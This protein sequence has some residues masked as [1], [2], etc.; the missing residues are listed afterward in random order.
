MGDFLIM[1]DL[2]LDSWYKIR[3]KALAEGQT[4]IGQR[5]NKD[6]PKAKQRSAKDQKGLSQRSN[7][8][9]PKAK[10][11]LAEGQSPPQELEVSPRSGL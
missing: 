9:W 11:A 4:R 6:R 2:D 8:D 1:G 7:K 10:K 5:P 3:L